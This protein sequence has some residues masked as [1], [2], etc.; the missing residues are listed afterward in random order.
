MRNPEFARIIAERRSAKPKIQT[1]PGPSAEV[2]EAAAK[3]ARSTPS[4]NASFPVRFVN[5]LS[6]EK[7][8]ELFVKALPADAD[9]AK[10]DR[11]RSKAMKGACA[12]A[13]IGPRPGPGTFPG[14]DMENLMTAGGALTNFLNVLYA[15]GF[16]AFT[17]TGRDFPDP[18]GLY[19][20][21]TERLLCFILCGTL[22]ESPEPR[23]ETASLLTEW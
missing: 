9:Q 3:A 22:A 12:I 4:H 14:E 20:P 21:K 10:I 6:R 16:G 8:A 5:V 11:A 2:L 13:V 17:V 15:E 1:Q 23:P 19:D 7:F 18:E